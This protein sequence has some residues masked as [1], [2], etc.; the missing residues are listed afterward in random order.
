MV[1]NPPRSSDE[2]DL[3]ELFILF[4]RSKLL[5]LSFVVLTTGIAA[6]YVFFTPV[7]YESS[8]RI[9]PPVAIDLAGYNASRPRSFKIR[10]LKTEDAY[11]YFLQ[12][13]A[14]D[15]VKIDFFENHYLPI[16]LSKANN[17]NKQEL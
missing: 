13:L 10:E 1:P 3:R 5:I 2:I 7:L 12:S 16:F 6:A 9:F 11:N 17:I 15:Q 14:S 4:W 8:A